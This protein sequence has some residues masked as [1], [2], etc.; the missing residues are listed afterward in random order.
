MITLLYRLF[1]IQKKKQQMIKKNNVNF[2]S[3]NR[4]N[5]LDLFEQKKQKNNDKYDLKRIGNEDDQIEQ[6]KRKNNVNVD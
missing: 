3:R 6:M 5:D 4:E 1:Q 2:D